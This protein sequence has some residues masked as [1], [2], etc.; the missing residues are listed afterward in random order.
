MANVRI[1]FVAASTYYSFI[2]TIEHSYKHYKSNKKIWEHNVFIYKL[3]DWC[4]N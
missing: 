4:I 3:D 2:D 1:V